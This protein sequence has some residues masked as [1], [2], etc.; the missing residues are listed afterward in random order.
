[1]LDTLITSKTRLQ[2]LLHFFLNPGHSSYL[3]RLANELSESTNAIRVELNR[4]EEAKL[5]I[6]ERKGREKWYS[7][8]ESHPLFP[9]LNSI[10]KK[11]MGLDKIVDE[12]LNNLGQL[13]LAVV[14][15]DYARGIDSGLIELV[16]VG[17][18]DRDYLKLLVDKAEQL[19]KRRIH[20]LIMDKEE[21]SQFSSKLVT[22]GSIVIWK[23]E[24][25]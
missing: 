13:E 15:G 25:G 20:T 10:V 17:K 23:E 22:D 6:S 7:A 2:L 24:K 19:L 5:L 1:M 8:N 11:V 9:E 3:R 16:V 18:V 21:F 4:L 14:T 12:I